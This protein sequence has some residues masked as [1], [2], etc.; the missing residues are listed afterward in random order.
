MIQSDS[1]TAIASSILKRAAIKV[2]LTKDRY[3]NLC[4][5]NHA[6]QVVSFTFRN[7][8]S[9]MQLT[10]ND[11]NHPTDF[12]RYSLLCGTERVLMQVINRNDSS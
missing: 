4:C 12:H 2:L 8:R 3:V 7:S 6:H 1:R 9:S 11:I 10:S 5:S